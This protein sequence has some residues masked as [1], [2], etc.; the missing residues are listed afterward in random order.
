MPG[1]DRPRR[2]P[3]AAL[4]LALT[5]SAL[6]AA[7]ATD[8]KEENNMPSTASETYDV[9]L[10]Q[11]ASQPVAVVRFEVAPDQLSAKL[12]EVLPAVYTYLAESGIEPGMPVSRYYSVSDDVLDM[13]AGMPVPEP[14]T[15]RGDI[16]GAELPGGSVAMTWHTGPYD[17]L[18]KAHQALTEWATSHDRQPV[19]GLWEIYVTDP[20]QE[21]DPNRWKTQVFLPLSD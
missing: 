7:S 6:H 13:E 19:E 14:V 15:G 18:D 16:V 3:T 9:E 17:Q 12:A 2:L 5:A 4:I 8:P 21:P 1:I 10:Q 20:G 11:I